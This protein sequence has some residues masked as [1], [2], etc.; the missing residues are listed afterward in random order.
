MTEMLASR[1]NAEIRCDKRAAFFAQR[2][3][4]FLL[5]HTFDSMELWSMGAPCFPNAVI[6]A[7]TALPD[8]KQFREMIR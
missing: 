1:L 7:D 4:R 8:T 5:A 2:M 3:N 6:T